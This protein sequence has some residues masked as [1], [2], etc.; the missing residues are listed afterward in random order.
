MNATPDVVYFD[1][2]NWHT[3][4]RSRTGTRIINTAEDPVKTIT[5]NVILKDTTLFFRW[6]LMPIND[7]ET[8]VRVCINDL[9]RNFKNRLLLP[10]PNTK[11]KSSVRQNL[12]DVLARFEVFRESFYFEFKGPARF[13]ETACI[14]INV[15]SSLR[16]KAAAMIATVSDL[17]LFV[18]QND[19]GLAGHPFVVFHTWDVFTDSINFDFCFPISR[20]NDVPEHPVINFRTVEAMDAI[21]SDFYGNYSIS[22]V[23]WYELIE[24]SKSLGYSMNN[25]LV[26]VYHNDPHSG[27]NELDWKAVVYLGIDP[28]NQVTSDQ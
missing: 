19:L 11:F 15:N 18:R 12:L 6:E 7:T 17:N 13:E 24:K 4:N 2:L 28:E 8:S 25:R 3:W 14:Y 26:E 5:S 23:T 10:F 1:I 9:E 22:D 16:G 27:G 21:K 20:V